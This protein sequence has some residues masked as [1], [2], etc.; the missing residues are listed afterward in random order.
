MLITL[1]SKFLGFGRDITLSYFYGASDVTDAY[2]IS[3]TVPSMLFGFIGIALTTAYIPMQS[4]IESSFG[5]EAGNRYTSNLANIVLLIISAIFIFAFC[6]AEGVVKLF[7]SG[8]Y[9]ETLN[10]AIAFTR[11]SLIGMYFTALIS[12][13]SG[14]LQI[15]GDYITPAIMGFPF[16]TIVI[17]SVIISSK[18]NTS[19]LVIGTVIAIAAQFF[20]MVPS[21]AQNG[22]KYYKIFELKD[23]R[24]KE[25]L[26]IALPVIIG[27]SVNQI[28]ILIDRTIA[29]TIS[30][31]GISSLS[32]ASR[33]NQFIQGVFITSI[34]VVVYPLISK[35]IVDNNVNGLKRTIKRSVISATIFLLP[36]TFGSMIFS[37]EIINILFGRG[38]FD[39]QALKMTTSSLF[40]YSIGML[41]FGMREILSR[42][43]YAMQDTITPVKNAAIGMVL[44]IV[45]NIILSQYLGIGGLAL[46]TSIAATCIT[47]LLFISLRKKTGPF[48]IKQ[49]SISFLKILFASLIMSFI[50]K[51]SFN[52]LTNI[53]PQSISLL[54]G[55]GIGA[56]SY[57]IIMYFMKVEE[58]DML[59]VTFKKKCKLS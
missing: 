1:L 11:I 41:G 10:L 36:I 47:I 54:M 4:K 27:A 57:F 9:G 37:S 31:G 19:I 48:G 23:S 44:N 5:V 6:F 52:Y 43:F 51:T 50:S 14:F 58:V 7:A 30:I 28:N 21:I 12:I 25:T 18:E 2:L 16:N 22:F 53:I 46:A 35:M 26:I 13:F 38:A 8:F 29:S 3:Q 24:I 49:I 17:I 59:V 40:F 33:L 32:Y 42:G 39:S 34:V 15:K 55:I 45:L 20:I 56:I